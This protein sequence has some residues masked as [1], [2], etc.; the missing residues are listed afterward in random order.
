MAVFA[1]LAYAQGVTLDALLVLRFGLAAVLLL[2]LAGARGALQHLTRRAVLTGLALGAVGYASQAGLYFA[3]LTRVDASQVALLFCTYPVLVML[4]AILSRRESASR[5]RVLALL[6]AMAGISLVLGGATA[7]HFEP[8]GATLALGSAIVYTA[9]ILVGDRAAA[10]VPPVPLAGLV[11]AGA[12]GTFLVTTVL[13]G[14]PD[15]RLS[16][17]AWLWIGLLVLLSTVGAIL[18]FFAGLS[19]VGPTAASL[20]GIIEPVVTVVSAAL[21]FGESLSLGQAVGGGVVLA[22]VLVIQWPTPA[23][24]HRRSRNAPAKGAADRDD[25]AR[26]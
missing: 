15:V 26:A 21:V 2:G 18:L 19:R 7:G 17:A 10:D 5:R 9:Y 12:F 4:A 1:K 8:V 3:A 14:G 20:L 11:C 23:H 13:T 25:L 24:E 22:A 6:L 16:V